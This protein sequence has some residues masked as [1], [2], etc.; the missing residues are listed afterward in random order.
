VSA[1]LESH[2]SLRDHPK[3]KKLARRLG[4]RLPEAIGILHCLWWWCLD[5]AQ[6]GDLTQ[7]EPD[8]IADGCEWGGDPDELLAC[9]VDCHF[10]DNGSGFIVHDWYEYAGRLIARREQDRKRKSQSRKPDVQRTSGGSPADGV[11]T[12]PTNTTNTTDST[13][14]E[15]MATSVAE[16]EDFWQYYPRKLKKQTALRAWMARVKDKNLPAEMIAAARIYADHCRTGHTE[17][18]YIMHAATFIGPDVPYLEWLHGIPAGAGSGDGSKS[19]SAADI[20][21][22]ADSADFMEEAYETD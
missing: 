1:W 9:L 15:L 11:R 16:F 5:Y 8:E 19:M 14:Q 12:Q 21:A 10:V 20:F 2:Q 13:N 6:D 17:P 4:V 7:Y 18:R 3:T 22:A